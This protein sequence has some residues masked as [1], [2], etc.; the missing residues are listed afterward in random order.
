MDKS[1][2]NFETFWLTNRWKLRILPNIV[3]ISETN[4]KKKM[5]YIRHFIIVINEILLTADLYNT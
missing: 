3:D 2:I 1:C 5:F 4:Y